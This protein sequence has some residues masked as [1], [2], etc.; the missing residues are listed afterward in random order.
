M[1]KTKEKQKAVILRKRGKSINEI[2]HTLGVSKSSVSTWCRDVILTES[3]KIH[4]EKA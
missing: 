2:A 4:Y 3:Q 1:A